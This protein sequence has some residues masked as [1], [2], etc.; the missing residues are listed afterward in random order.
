MTLH[1]Y[2]EHLP[3]ECSQ[4]LMELIHEGKTIQPQSHNQTSTLHLKALLNYREIQKQPHPLNPP[5][6]K[7]VFYLILC[8]GVAADYISWIQPVWRPHVPFHL[9]SLT[10]VI[11][12]NLALIIKT[13]ARRTCCFMDPGVLLYDWFF[14]HEMDC[15]IALLVT[16][17][18]KLNRARAGTGNWYDFLY[19][20]NSLFV[21]GIWL[22]CNFW[23]N[24]SFLPIPIRLFI[25]LANKNNLVF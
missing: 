13:S 25:Y 5:S 24:T 22:M 23:Q 9:N 4:T 14:K 15:L 11:S 21:F 17:W 18:G 2:L 7:N 20:H 19:K 1:V 10:L 3:I 16:V 6:C 12:K 8:S